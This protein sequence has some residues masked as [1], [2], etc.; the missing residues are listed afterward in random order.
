MFDRL[1]L[2]Y[3]KNKI[4]VDDLNYKPENA[5]IS[6]KLINPE[7]PKLAVVFPPWH[8]VQTLSNVLCRRLEK[9]GWAVL[10]YE[11][12]TQILM[13]D[14]SMVLDSFNYIQQTISNDLVSLNKQ[15]AYSQIRFIGL[16]LGSV[17]LAMVADR[18]HDFDT[19]N[20]VVGGDDLALCM[21]YGERTRNVRRAFEHHHLHVR[22]LDRDWRVLA[23]KGHIRHFEGK[24]TSLVISKTDTI[25]PS[26]YQERLK[27][28]IEQVGGNV[29][30][31]YTLLGHYLSVVRY[32]LWGS[33]D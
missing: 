5:L 33:V 14:E 26:K 9:R 23:P 18:F 21:W 30:P 10:I 25:I 4:E 29:S 12:N 32:C 13:A 11:F 7:G 6:R 8:G 3:S 20:I 2:L 1:F 22:K 24:T 31:R 27:N 28:D 16:S 19:V 17:A 15:H